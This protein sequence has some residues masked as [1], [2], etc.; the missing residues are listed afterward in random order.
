MKDREYRCSECLIL[1]KE[2][3]EY[4]YVC[5]ECKLKEQSIVSLVTEI[6]DLVK[7]YDV[8]FIT[9]KGTQ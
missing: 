3:M 4:P 9:A 6:G 1:Q 8:K 5:E 2:E 7:K